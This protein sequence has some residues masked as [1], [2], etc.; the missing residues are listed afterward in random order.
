[1]TKDQIEEQVKSENNEILKEI[2]V[3]RGLGTLDL[4][5]FNYE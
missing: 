3:N 5:F 2:T 1:M 4:T